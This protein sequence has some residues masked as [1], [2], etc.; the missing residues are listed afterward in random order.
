MVTRFTKTILTCFCS[1]FTEKEENSG[2]VLEDSSRASLSDHTIIVQKTRG[3][4]RA[5]QQNRISSKSTQQNQKLNGLKIS[6]KISSQHCTWSPP[7]ITGCG[8]RTCQHHDQVKT[9]N[10]ANS[11]SSPMKSLHFASQYIRNWI[12]YIHRRSLAYIIQFT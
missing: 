8:Y 11:C 9:S 5:N 7:G 10:V 3:L 12:T 2:S 1:F 6:S 4:N